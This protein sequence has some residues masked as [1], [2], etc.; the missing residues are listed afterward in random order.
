MPDSENNS[1][2]EVKLKLQKIIGLDSVKEYVLKLEDNVNAQKLR[3]SSGLKN[4]SVSMNMIFTGNPGTGKTTIARLVAEYL[5]A[6]GVISEGQ[7]IEV[8]RNDLVGEYQGQTAQ[9]TAEKIKSAIGGVLFIDEAYALCRNA[10]DT[11]GLEAI[12]T[13]VK[14]MEDNKD[15]LVVILAGYSNEMRE[16]LK[17]NSGLKSRFPNIID[18]PDYTPQE[19]YKIAAELAKSNDYIIAE[20]CT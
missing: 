1:L 2:E 12:D 5:K 17:N 6:L 16:F 3:E 10:N 13:I 18:F 11:Y 14:M 7:L 8:S 19:M 9:K 4:S 20:E 15:D